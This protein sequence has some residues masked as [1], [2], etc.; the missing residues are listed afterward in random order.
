MKA[1]KKSQDSASKL[2]PSTKNTDWYIIAIGSFTMLKGK[3]QIEMRE[4][5]LMNIE[6][7]GCAG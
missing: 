2:Y 1:F 6:V 7:I 3:P 4:P 5:R